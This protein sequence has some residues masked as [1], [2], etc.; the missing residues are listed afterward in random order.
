MSLDNAVIFVTGAEMFA[1]TTSEAM[2]ALRRP[3]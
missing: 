2:T 3:P 1:Q